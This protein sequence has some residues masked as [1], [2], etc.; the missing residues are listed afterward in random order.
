MQQSGFRLYAFSFDR[1]RAKLPFP[2]M[3]GCYPCLPSSA[4]PQLPILSNDWAWSSFES[5]RIDQ[6]FARQSERLAGKLYLGRKP[7]KV[8]FIHVLLI[9]LPFLGNNSRLCVHR[10]MT[11]SFVALS[12]FRF[13]SRSAPKAEVKAEIKVSSS[14]PRPF[15]IRI[16]L[17]L[18]I[19][20][21]GV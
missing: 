4:P 18:I 6:A 8:G 7:G 21:H 9:V 11:F 17:P 20:Y 15:P 16:P 3:I 1:P 2:S 12:R 5:F 19:R 14:P 10:L 13:I